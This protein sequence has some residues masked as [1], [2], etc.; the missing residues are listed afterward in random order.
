MYS[1][2][3]LILSTFCSGISRKFPIWR[4]LKRRLS[5]RQ[6]EDSESFCV[7]H[8]TISRAVRHSTREEN[9]QC[10]NHYYAIFHNSSPNSFVNKYELRG[11]VSK[12]FYIVFG[13]EKYLILWDNIHA[14]HYVIILLHAILSLINYYF[15]FVRYSLKYLAEV[16]ILW[17][18]RKTELQES[19]IL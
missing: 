2:L 3:V 10:Y 17:Q 16:R 18:N 6:H 19:H 8:T 1:L 11:M 5:L 9:K 13:E 14:R 7:T 4:S 12:N 15:F